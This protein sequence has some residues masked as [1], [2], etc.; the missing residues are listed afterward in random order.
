MGSTTFKEAMPGERYNRLTVLHDYGMKNGK[1]MV[2]CKCDCG[3]VRDFHLDCI[4]RKWHPTISCGC[5][6]REMSSSKHFKH[7]ESGGGTYQLWMS[8]KARCYIDR[9]EYTRYKELRIFV[10]DGWLGVN[11]YLNF[12]K[13][14]GEKPSVLHTTIDRI[15]NDGNYTCGRCAQCVSNK[16]PIN[17]RWATRE[18]QVNNRMNNIIVVFMQESMTLGQLS[19][20]MNISYSALFGRYKRG[21]SIE[22]IVDVLLKNKCYRK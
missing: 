12:K 16:W 15:D 3:T 17:A 18:M 7:G 14:I 8:M 21:Q 13:D 20:K 19:K 4:R 1:H 11:G 6:N 10:C 5:Y 22:S 2:S 9:P